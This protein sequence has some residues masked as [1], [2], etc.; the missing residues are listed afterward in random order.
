MTELLVSWL[1]WG[2]ALTDSYIM[3]FGSV[4]NQ[5]LQQFWVTGHSKYI[6]Y[7][8]FGK[9]TTKS[10][11][12]LFHTGQN[13]HVSPLTS[14]NVNVYHRVLLPGLFTLQQSRVFTSCSSTRLWCRHNTSVDAVIL[15][16]FAA[17][18]YDTRCN[19]WT[20]A[21]KW[22]GRRPLV[23]SLIWLEPVR[24]TKQ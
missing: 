3:E 13:I 24:E 14:G 21:M 10:H 5:M 2:S 22:R 8:Q 18:R 15:D 23:V 17:R 7:K 12:F 20:V 1:L 11:Y 19:I 6:T 9:I 4:N 16:P